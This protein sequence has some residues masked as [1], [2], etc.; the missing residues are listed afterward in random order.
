M[1]I[2]GRVGFH[3][4]KKKKTSRLIFLVLLTVRPDTLVDPDTTRDLG[5]REGL[6]ARNGCRTRHCAIVSL[7]FFPCWYSLLFVDEMP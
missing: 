3:V 4:L 6:G 2:D 5:G 1:K 7:V